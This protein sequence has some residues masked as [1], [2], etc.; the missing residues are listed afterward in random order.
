[1][2]SKHLWAAVALATIG[3]IGVVVIAFAVN[4]HSWAKTISAV[5]AIVLWGVFITIGWRVWPEWLLS[6]K[7]PKT[8]KET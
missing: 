1:M 3:L 5:S 4:G 2:K 8:T 6:R 7:R